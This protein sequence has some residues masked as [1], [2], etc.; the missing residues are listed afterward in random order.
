MIL[1]ELGR[2][3][4]GDAVKKVLGLVEERSGIP[5]HIE[6]DPDL[7]GTLLA[8]V[9]MARGALRLHR[10]LYRPNSSTPPDYLICQQAGFILRHFGCPPEK[11]F[12]FASAEAG[13]RAVEKLIKAHPVAKRLPPQSLPQFCQVLRDGFLYHL[14][15][16]PV[17][18]RVDLWLANEFPELRQLQKESVL[19]QVQDSASTLAPHQQEMTPKEIFDVTQRISAA[20]TIFWGEQLH[21]PQLALPFKAAGYGQ[22]GQE[23]L[24]LWESTPDTP[25]NDRLLVDRWAEKLGVAGWYRWVPYSEP[26]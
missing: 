22:G 13:D 4:F 5:V 11:R 24:Q 12:D 9:L 10:V 26:K 14:R 15:S 25:E 7:P 8:K 16:I 23:L 21:Q 18:M 6:P 2:M 3:I 17:G 20:F 19:R 1:Y